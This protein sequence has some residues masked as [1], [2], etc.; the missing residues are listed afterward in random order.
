MFAGR[1]STI[2]D[3][4]ATSG[5]IEAARLEEA[6]RQ[7]QSAGGSFADVVVL[8]GG[9]PRAALLEAIANHLGRNC[10]H[11]LPAEVP[12]GAR[13]LIPER[14]ARRL[15]VIPVDFAGLRLRVAAIDPLTP[16]LEDEVRFTLGREVELVITDPVEVAR[17]LALQVPA[18]ESPERETAEPDFD[19]PGGNSPAA[20]RVDAILQH[21]VEAGASDIH[22]EPSD[23]ALRVRFRVDGVLRDAPSHPAG[24][25]A[26]II[27][28]FKVVGGLNVAESRRPQDGR[29][30]L[31]VS[32]REIDL[33]ISTLPTQPGESVVLRLLDAGATKLNLADLGLPSALT[34]RFQQAIRRPNGLVLVTGPTGSGKT[35]TLYS[36]LREL[37]VPSAKLLTIEDPV[38]Y[39][40]EGIMQVPLNPAAGLTFAGALRAFLRHDP[41]II[42]VGEIRDLETAQT[43][44]QASLTGHLVLSTLHT[45]DAPAAVTR[46]FDMGVEPFLLASSLEAVLAQRLVRRTCPGCRGVRDACEQCGGIGYRG[47]TGIYELM[48]MSDELRELVAA[49]AD[50]RSLQEAA[51]RDGLVT[52][53][54]AGDELVAAGVTTADEVARFI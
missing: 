36:A 27:S 52:L 21:A 4:L 3:L 37:N 50:L 47:R 8:G 39:E 23:T 28:R 42:M 38:E 43:A 44:I 45:N 30:R 25:S 26:R 32:G 34:A 46:L 41:D 48:G 1:D 6:W 7:H 29:I 20:A 33:R 35:T 54:E 53:R 2:F 10:L 5:L 22:L 11:L 13:D 31:R 14:L 12:P 18:G 17:L 15:G 51:R 16:G 49:G 9:L 19:L 24:L 40:L